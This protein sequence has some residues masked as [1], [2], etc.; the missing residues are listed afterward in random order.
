MQL[1]DNVN[2]YYEYDVPV[3]VFEKFEH[4]YTI[5]Y[6][7]NGNKFDI[8]TDATTYATSNIGDNVVLKYVSKHKLGMQEPPILGPILWFILFII[9][10]SILISKTIID[11]KTYKDIE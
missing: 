5:V 11:W 2:N 3:T 4:G 9:S 8:S 7:S 1:N 6:D 10:G